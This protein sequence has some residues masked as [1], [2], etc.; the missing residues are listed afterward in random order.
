MR[1]VLQIYIRLTDNQKGYQYHTFVV[2]R[3]QWLAL[4]W[5]GFSYVSESV[6]VG[7][8]SGAGLPPPWSQP[9]SPADPENKIMCP[10]KV[11]SEEAY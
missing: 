1:S 2:P 8:P 7:V 4:I 5:Q 11:P 6:C 3:T 9:A 10:V